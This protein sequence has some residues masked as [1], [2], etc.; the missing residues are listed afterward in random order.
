MRGANSLRF[1]VKRLGLFS[2]TRST[3]FLTWWLIPLSARPSYLMAQ[4][5]GAGSLQG[6]LDRRPLVL[7]WPTGKL[8]GWAKCTVDDEGAAVGRNV[9]S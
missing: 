5:A 6:K 7:V 2:C 9:A 1:N 4:Q 8:M 3:F